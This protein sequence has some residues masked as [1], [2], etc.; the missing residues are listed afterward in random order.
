MYESKKTK[1]WSNGWI[2]KIQEDIDELVEMGF[3]FVSPKMD[4]KTGIKKIQQIAE[5]RGGKCLS[6]VYTNNQT[7]LKFECSNKHTFQMPPYSLTIGRWCRKCYE[8]EIELYTDQM[9]QIL[10]LSGR[11]APPVTR[12]MPNHL[13]RMKLVL[14]YLSSL[15]LVTLVDRDHIAPFFWKFLII[16]MSVSE[17]NNLFC[18]SWGV[19]WRPWA[20][21]G[22]SK[23]A[24]W[25]K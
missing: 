21:Q 10:D 12:R 7:P 24:G 17:L 11:I 4:V 3:E 18:C 15:L 5:Q 23:E 9:N 13:L 25:K 14:H 22:L 6:T 19:F 16:I 20:S 8:D 1:G 2:E